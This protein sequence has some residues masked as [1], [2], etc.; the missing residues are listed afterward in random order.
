[1][2]CTRK[3]HPKDIQAQ[4]QFQTSSCCH[5]WNNH[6]LESRLLIFW[7]Y[8]PMIFAEAAW[9]H[10]FRVVSSWVSP[11]F[12]RRRQKKAFR[13]TR[14][15]PPWS[16]AS[17]TRGADEPKTEHGWRCSFTVWIL[18]IDI[19]L[20]VDTDIL[21]NVVYVLINTRTVSRGI[22]QKAKT[23]KL[24]LYRVSVFDTVPITSYQCATVHITPL[25]HMYWM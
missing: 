12:P 4:A 21:F 9:H 7:V 1:M 15:A 17:E 20:D 5:Q 19:I 10:G 18:I 8:Y 16:A 11:Q 13:S 6:S 3:Q 24:I 23:T 25:F 2:N 22:L 14:R